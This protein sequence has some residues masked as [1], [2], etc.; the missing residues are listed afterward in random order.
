VNSDQLLLDAV[1]RDIVMA[2]LD[3]E[4]ANAELEQLLA[5]ARAAG[6]P[7]RPCRC[8]PSLVLADGDFGP[9][10]AKC[11]RGPA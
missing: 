3:V 11:G 7:A 8:E 9:S 1:L 4:G 5:E 2:D 10:C 6:A